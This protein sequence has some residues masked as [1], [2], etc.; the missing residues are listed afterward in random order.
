MFVCLL[1]CLCVS[2]RCDTISELVKAA[3]S[4][5][6]VDDCAWADCYASLTSDPKG[7]KKPPKTTKFKVTLAHIE[8]HPQKEIFPV[9]DVSQK[10][11]AEVIEHSYIPGSG[12]YLH[13][14]G[15]VFLAV[16]AFLS[17]STSCQRKK[18]NLISR[19][20]MW[21]YGWVNSPATGLVG[22]FA[23]HPRHFF[24]SSRK[25]QI[26]LPTN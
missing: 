5:L 8:E 20:H 19:I 2:F 7:L 10:S 24:N 25:L 21:I 11:E 12:D 22:C 9:S 26:Q 15:C 23:T 3:S 13:Q 4:E 17:S 6:Y 14:G 18:R 1:V 16:C